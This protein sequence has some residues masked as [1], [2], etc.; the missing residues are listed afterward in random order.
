[1]FLAG[2]KNDYELVEEQKNYFCARYLWITCSLVLLLPVVRT[3]I[4]GL[5]E[6][7]IVQRELQRPEKWLTVLQMYAVRGIIVFVLLLATIA[8]FEKVKYETVKT[9][10][11]IIAGKNVVRSMNYKQF[12]IPLLVMFGIYTLGI[13]SIIR[14]DFLY[15][16]D[17]G[18]SIQGYRGWDNFSRHINNFLAILIH[19][20][21]R[22]SDISPLT[23]LIAAFFIAA[24]SIAL[25]YILN[26]GKI[27]K[28]ALAASLPIGLSPYFLECFSYKFDSPYMALSILVSIVPFVFMHNRRIFS[29]AS[30]IGILFM[31][32]TYQASSGIY[33]IIVIFLCFLQWNTQQKTNKEIFSFMLTSAI[34]YGVGLL[35][36][37]IFIMNSFNTYVSSSFASVNGILHNFTQ[38]ISYIWNDFGRVWTVLLLLV[39]LAFGIKTITTTKRNKLLALL[40]SFIIVAVMVVL[41]YGIY[42]VIE[43]PL[44]APRGMYGFG[45]F[46]ALLGIYTAC[47]PKRIFAI[48]ALAL[49]WCFFVFSFAYGNALSAQK[50]YIDFRIEILLYDLSVLF[51]HQHNAPPLPIKLVDSAGHAPMVHNIGVRNPIIFRLVPVHLQGNSWAWGSV[52]LSLY[53]FNFDFRLNDSIE[54]ELLDQIF[55]SRYHT[56][57]RD[58]ERVIVILK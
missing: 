23:H 34:S 10:A 36:F 41:S 1:M 32:M 24:S 2:E 33:I 13:S 19:T 21:T 48:P 11:E 7:F 29:V 18:R 14:A 16:D 44:Y 45:A 15:I 31:Y 27:T 20:D 47:Q 37:R 40:V 56:I 4:V 22:I 58:A 12:I 38:Y 30:I 43:K 55:D 35:I 51:P 57:K 17:I 42:L 5:V 54:E 28:T 8:Y 6:T 3:I 50:K 25:V 52:M 9:V 26:G 53:K 46:I 49:C 39:I